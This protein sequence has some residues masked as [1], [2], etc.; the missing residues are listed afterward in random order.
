[1]Q[2]SSETLRSETLE[3]TSELDATDLVS[4]VFEQRI[5]VAHVQKITS[6]TAKSEKC[7]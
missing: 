7:C 4:K 2:P 6:W 3:L 5:F 1:M